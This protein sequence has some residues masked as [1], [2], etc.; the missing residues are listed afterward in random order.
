MPRFAHSP[1]TG[2]APPDD[3]AAGHRH[4]VRDKV[5][6]I[7]PWGVSIILHLA[8]VVLAYFVIWSTIA[9]PQQAVI[10][11]IANLSRTPGV[12]VHQRQLE[13]VRMQR[14]DHRS[15]DTPTEAS[16]SVP[17]ELPAPVLGLDAAAPTK[18]SPFDR[19]QQ[20]QRFTARFLGVEGGDARQVAFLI[21]ASGTMIDTLPFVLNEL[22][23]TLNKLSDG[24]TFTVV[25]FQGDDV[26]EVPPLGMKRADVQTRRR[27][28]QW[29]DQPGHV[30]PRGGTN[31]LLAI[32][33]VL[34]YRPQVLFLLSDDITGQGRYKV[35][36]R[37]LLAEIDRANTGGT[38]ISTIQFIYRDPLAEVPGRRGTLELIAERTGGSYKFLDASE[39]GL[40]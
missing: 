36:Q 10:V 4:E 27:V 35:E 29:I 16:L 26:I 31:P 32:Q 7:L 1:T 19:I 9:A 5:D 12:Q 11:P 23:A 30:V 34:K 2:A 40:E 25:F 13:R 14:S 8:I 18:A 17:V 21:D 28:I 20:P 3:R 15:V 22:K 38:R 39:L 24:Q 6:E 33:Y 37:R